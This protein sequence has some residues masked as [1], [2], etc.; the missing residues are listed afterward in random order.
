AS[1]KEMTISSLAQSEERL[2]FI[3]I[4]RRTAE[5]M[6][7]SKRLIPHVTHAD[8]ADGG[9]LAGLRSEMKEEAEK[10]KVKLT[11]LTFIIKALTKALK[12]FP[13]LNSSLDEE[14]Q[15]IVL[16]KYYHIGMATA[17]EHGLVV[18]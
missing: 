11:Y 5:K 8:E 15:Q 10:K 12:Q 4:R 17:T 2:P 16:K 3:G 18:P 7:Q 14:H 13:N 6:V 1:F 9:A